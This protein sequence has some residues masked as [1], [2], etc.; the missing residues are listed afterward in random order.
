MKPGELG[1]STLKAL[2][3]SRIRPELDAQSI[4][5]A[6]TGRDRPVIIFTGGQPGAGKIHAN[7]MAKYNRPSLVEIVGG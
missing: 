7:A 6:M 2:F 3:E 5:G 1:E 4:P